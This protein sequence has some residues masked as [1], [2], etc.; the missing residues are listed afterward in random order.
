VLGLTP[1][2][3]LRLDLGE[4][5]TALATLPLLNSALELAGTLAPP[6]PPP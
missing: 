6:P 2:L 5:A 3:D 1:V 4:G